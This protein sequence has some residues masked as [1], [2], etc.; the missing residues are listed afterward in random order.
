MIGPLLSVRRALAGAAVLGLTARVAHGEPAGDRSRAGV[1]ASGLAPVDGWRDRTGAGGGLGVWLE[2]PVSPHVVVTARAGALMHAP[3]TIA[4]G[5]QL[6]LIEVPVLG[7]ARLEVAR[8]GRVRGLLGGDVGL[9]VA[10]ERV[11]L[12][13]VTEADTGLRFGA[14]LSAGVAVDRYTVEVGP[15][16]ADLTD[17]D[18]SIGFQLT[19][20]ARLR[21]W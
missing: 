19:F 5:A 8:S 13:G 2:V 20:A 3:A 21:S 17:L 6:W 18:H 10:Y 15:W 1:V 12:G 9:V 16:L 4:A 7:G 14:S 11:S